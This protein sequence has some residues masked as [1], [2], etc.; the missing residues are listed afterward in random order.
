MGYLASPGTSINHGDLSIWI[1]PD[2]WML[3]KSHENQHQFGM[4]ES[5]TE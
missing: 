2:L 3:K 4:V 5:R 1:S